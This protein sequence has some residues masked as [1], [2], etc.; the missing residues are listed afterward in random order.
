M[1]AATLSFFNLPLE[2]VVGNHCHTLMHGT[3]EPVEI[4]P[5]SK[6]MKT[7]EH[8]ETELYDDKTDAWFYVSADP[9][10]D[11]KGEM[12]LLYRQRHYA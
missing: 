2:R 10:L 9:I 8:E 3:N 4:C 5:F 1:N 7:K 11:E 12:T 6:M